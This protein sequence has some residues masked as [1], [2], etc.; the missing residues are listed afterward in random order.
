MTVII[1]FCKYRNIKKFN[2]LS[3]KSKHSFLANLFDDLDKFNKLKPQ[4]KETKEKENKCVDKAFDLY[5]DLVEMYF[6][7]Y[8]EVSHKKKVK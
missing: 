4:N 5:S 2:N 8:Y 1:V 6:D 3:S 7:E